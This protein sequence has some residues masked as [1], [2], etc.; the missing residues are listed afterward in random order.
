[1]TFFSKVRIF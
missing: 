1:M